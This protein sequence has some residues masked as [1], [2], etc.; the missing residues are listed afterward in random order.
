M[1]KINWIELQYDCKTMSALFFLARN[2][3]SYL[4]FQKSMFRYRVIHPAIE[5]TAK[6]W[7]QNSTAAAS[8][9]QPL[10]LATAPVSK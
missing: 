6:I 4:Q 10:K 7:T 9:P 3:V 2:H 1:N 5:I 8:L